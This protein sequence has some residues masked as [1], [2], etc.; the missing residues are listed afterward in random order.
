MMYAIE[1]QTTVKR[2][3]PAIPEDKQS[4]LRGHSGEE[5]VRVIV[6]TTPAEQ[7]EPRADMLLEAKSKGYDDFFEY[8]LDNPLN[9]ASPTRYSRDELYER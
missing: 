5:A 8:L 2:I 6:L 9:I 1:F 7:T 3:L 4:S